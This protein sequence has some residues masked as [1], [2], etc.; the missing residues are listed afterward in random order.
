MSSTTNKK[1]ALELSRKLY[2]L[3]EAAS[4]I[5]CTENQL[6]EAGAN[7]K[8]SIHVR[9]PDDLSVFSIAA[10]GSNDEQYSLPRNL[11]PVQEKEISYL[12][13]SDDDCRRVILISN[14]SQ[15]EFTNG[16]SMG[17]DDCLRY[18]PIVRIPES[19]TSGSIFKLVTCLREENISN[20]T[21]KAIS[22]TPE[23]LLVSDIA[24][25]KYM[26]ENQ[27]E[28]KQKNK[29]RKTPP[30]FTEFINALLDEII[31]KAKNEGIT[32]DR[33]KLPFDKKQL[34]NV[35]IKKPYDLNE[36]TLRT[37][38]D[39]MQGICKFQHGKQPS[40]SVNILEKLYPDYHGGFKPQV[41]KVLR[42]AA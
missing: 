1:P 7:K 14:Y 36:I 18:I 28:S 29:G 31:E 26:C 40:G 9:C 39:Y 12:K 41:Q 13:L 23:K 27:L 10:E 20:L 25:Q 19:V 17:S 2:S 42:D 5:A 35:W 22:L 38:S 32:V 33:N 37:F 24:L 15:C 11:K 21:R 16:Y 34:F 4:R 8:I 30:K 6:L 3:T